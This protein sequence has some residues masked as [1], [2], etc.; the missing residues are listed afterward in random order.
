MTLVRISPIERSFFRRIDGAFNLGFSFTESSG[1]GQ[2]TMTGNATFRR[3]AFELSASVS[4]YVTRQRDADDTDRQNLQFGYLKRLRHR[5]VI[6]GLGIVDRNPELGFEYRE[7]AA[8]IL[9]QRLL[10]SNR[11]DLSLGG[12]LAVSLEKPLD[13]ESSTNWDALVVTTGNFYTYDSPKTSL[14]YSVL[15]YPGL[16]DR[17]RIRTEVNLAVSRELFR[18]FTVGVSGYDSYDN[19]PPTGDS[20]SHDFGVTLTIGW[21]F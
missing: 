13:G 17:G 7:T 21:K 5:W 15:V 18:N 10:Q 20:A 14:S 4:S 19:R 2:L 16:S 11:G 8:L 3:P 6:G 1:V 12:G 9:G